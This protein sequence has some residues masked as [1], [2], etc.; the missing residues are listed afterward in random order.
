MTKK[1]KGDLILKKDLYVE[2]DLI[3]SGNIFRKDNRRYNLI[4]EGSVETKISLQ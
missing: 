4:V 1:I 2:E 3:V